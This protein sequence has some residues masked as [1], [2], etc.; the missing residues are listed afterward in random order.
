MTRGD[1]K[2]GKS[3]PSENQLDH[4]SRQKLGQQWEIVNLLNFQAHPPKTVLTFNF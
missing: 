4:S 1:R 3:Y 2:K